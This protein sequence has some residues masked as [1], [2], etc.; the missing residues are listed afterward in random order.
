MQNLPVSIFPSGQ[1]NTSLY[2]ASVNQNADSQKFTDIFE[3]NRMAFE[4]ELSRARK[5][6]GESDILNKM[7]N[8]LFSGGTRSLNKN[9]NDVTGLFSETTVPR[10]SF[11]ARQGQLSSFI[12]PDRMKY[13][14]LPSDFDALTVKNG[15]LS[16]D[17]I[18]ILKD[19]LQDKGAH[20]ASLDALNQLMASGVPLTLATATGKLTGESRLHEELSDDE[21]SVFRLLG[22]KMG[23]NIL[24]ADDMLALSDS[25]N[26]KEL[27]NR[28]ADKMSN[29][30][31]DSLDLSKKE[32]EALLKSLD[33][34]SST[35]KLI[36]SQFPEGKD[37]ITL[38]KDQLNDFFS[39]VRSELTA[40]DN[41]QRHCASI[42][43]SAV[44]ET[45]EQRKLAHKTSLESDARN[46]A[47]ADRME[48]RIQESIL[49]KT[50]ATDFQQNEE[51]LSHDFEEEM[52]E[53]QLPQNTKQPEIADK[54]KTESTENNL[55][56][57]TANYS[58]MEKT[59]PLP[60]LHTIEAQPAENSTFLQGNAKNLEQL[61]QQHRQEIFHQVQS[62][63]VKSFNNGTTQLTLQLD[64]KDLGQLSLILTAREGEIRATIRAENAETAA[65]LSEQLEHL[66]TVLEEQGLKVAELEVKTGLQND[67]NQQ[68]WQGSQE[69]NQRY[70]AEQQAR[71]KRL[72][73]IRL[74]SS[75]DTTIKVHTT[76]TA[77]D[78]LHVVA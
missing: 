67:T 12:E 6:D 3:E 36:L 55:G 78:G 22:N 11:V 23:V 26:A 8:A 15:T 39:A 18:N 24:E 27:W 5:E 20:D 69:H 52:A 45:L 7:G 31:N 40:R 75:T 72:A 68:H 74:A 37:S 17:D 71:N 59:A 58:S 2:S 57:L 70:E 16:H 49:Q 43:G 33:L 29:M 28:L 25:G 30:E 14:D 32:A 4:E 63:L 56:T 9:I 34:S 62:G 50:G 53:N 38:G 51:N 35:R 66:R 13:T 73:Q 21:R 48:A 44:N 54:S 64:P 76:T 10:K 77:K 46:S 42:L 1:K 61:A 60:G 47:S 19:I 65:A 41:A